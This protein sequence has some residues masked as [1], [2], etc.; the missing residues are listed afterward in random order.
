VFNIVMSLGGITAI[1]GLAAG[2]LRQPESIS[3]GLMAVGVVICVLTWKVRAHVQL[4]RAE[5]S[6]K[7]AI[8]TQATRDG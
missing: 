2:A 6:S 4:L 1:C 8:P 3:L 7:I 5:A